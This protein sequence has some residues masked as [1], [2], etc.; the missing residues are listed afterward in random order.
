MANLVSSPNGDVLIDIL[1]SA[2]SHTL[3]VIY[4]L[5]T[6]HKERKHQSLSLI[7]C[8]FLCVAVCP[9]TDVRNNP[10]MFLKLTNCTVLEGHLQILLIDYAKSDEYEHLHFPMLREITDYLLLY[11][12]YGLRT[13]AQIF[14]NLS[15]IRGQ[16]LFFNYALVAF[17]MP[18]MEE[19]GLSALTTIERGAIRLEKN[20]NLCYIDTI[21]WDYITRRVTDDNFIVQNKDVDECPNVCPVSPNVCHDIV[22]D[23]GRRQQLCW[24]SESCQISK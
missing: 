6:N 12:V 11:R 9:T 2:P 15:V 19:L 4:T 5:P 8:V 1:I 23:A 24:N 16:K 20:P 18:D 21:N 7:I 17:E 13:L 10:S 22:M 14:P 3:C